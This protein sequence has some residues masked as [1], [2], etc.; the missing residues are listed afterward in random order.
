VV[1]RTAP[2]G[3]V[4]DADGYVLGTVAPLRPLVLVIAVLATACSGV[5]DQLDG[6]L[7]DVQSTASEVADRTQFCFAVTRALTSI[8]GGSTPEQARAAAEEVLAQAPEEVRDD[9]SLVAERLD[10]AV[11]EDDT[12]VLDDEF[13]AAAERLRDDTRKLCDPTS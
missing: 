8:D 3:P 10:Q 2:E 1:A 5:S 9:A 4:R 6:R 11:R 12:S 13:R 7:D